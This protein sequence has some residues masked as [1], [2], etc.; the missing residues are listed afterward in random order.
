MEARLV[1]SIG[2]RL[3]A[4]EGLFDNK[5]PSG[6]DQPRFFPSENKNIRDYNQDGSLRI[7]PFWLVGLLVG[8]IRLMN[9]ND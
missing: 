9:S 1:H 2:N 5:M 6:W 4:A 8:C 7:I 3:A